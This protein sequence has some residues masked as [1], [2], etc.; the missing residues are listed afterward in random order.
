LAALPPRALPIASH[1]KRD[2][3]Q[4]LQALHIAPCALPGLSP[5]ALQLRRI[6]LH[7]Q[8]LIIL[9]TQDLIILHTQDL[10]ILH[11]QDLIILHTEDLH[12]PLSPLTT[13]QATTLRN[14]FRAFVTS[15]QN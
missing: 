7:T 2:I 13:F 1:V 5:W 8:D 3:A 6:I 4:Q 10:I 12:I 11:T 15:V 14:W 9:R